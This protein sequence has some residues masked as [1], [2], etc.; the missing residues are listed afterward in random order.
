M[1]AANNKLL[2]A[3][4]LHFLQGI[5]EYEPRVVH[6]LLDFMYRNVAEV[7]Q[8]AEASP[9]HSIVFNSTAL[10][11]V[12]CEA[13]CC[14]TAALA[15]APLLFSAHYPRR[16]LYEP[17]KHCPKHHRQPMFAT[18]HQKVF[19]VAGASGSQG[20]SGSSSWQ[21]NLQ[22]FKERAGLNKKGIGLEDV[23]LAIQ[24]KATTSFVTPPSQEASSLLTASL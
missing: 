20:R 6:Q 23:M 15:L 7:L 22:A 21:C 2:V 24:A 9:V 16:V 10:V 11:A 3:L 1:K 13:T 4:Q 12:I 18:S 5:K 19:L 14:S 17:P 8:V